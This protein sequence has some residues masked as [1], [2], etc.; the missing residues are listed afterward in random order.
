MQL[1]RNAALHKKKKSAYV[2]I[3]IKPTRAR[4]STDLAWIQVRSPRLRWT[5]LFEITRWWNAVKCTYQNDPRGAHLNGRGVNG[6]F[7]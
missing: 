5:R 6:R 1:E 4:L 3:I 7:R 2:N